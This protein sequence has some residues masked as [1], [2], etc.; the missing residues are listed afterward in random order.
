MQAQ[1]Y[2][3]HAVLLTCAP[4]EVAGWA[5]TLRQLFPEALD[6]IPA[7]GTVVV[8]GVRPEHAIARLEDAAPRPIDPTTGT[9][10]ELPTIYDGQHLQ[11]VARWWGCS[12][13]EVRS[14]HQECEFKVAF[15]GFAPGFAYLVGLPEE[16][17]VPRLATPLRSVPSGAVGLA[18]R[19]SAVYPRSSPGGW[20]L[21][22]RTETSLWDLAATPPAL[23]TPGTRVRFVDA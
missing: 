6:V 12:T 8:D 9:L 10:V 15:C 14:I 7:A 21:I 17:H 19:F 20:Q 4:D 18:G 1:A 23:L 13:S 11:D 22:G 16:L 5:I 2:G 3:E